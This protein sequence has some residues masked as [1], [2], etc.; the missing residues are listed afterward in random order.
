M[1]VQSLRGSLGFLF[2]LPI[3]SG[4]HLNE[5]QE[6]EAQWGAKH[7]TVPHTLEKGYIL[8]QGVDFA[9]LNGVHG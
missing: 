8:S 2:F 4:F 5:V 1:W 6:C 3:Y 9:S 7:P